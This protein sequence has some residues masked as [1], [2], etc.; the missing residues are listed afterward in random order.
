MT[1][2]GRPVTANQRSTART[3]AAVFGKLGL[4]A[5][6]GLPKSWTRPTP[7]MHR[8]KGL[9]ETALLC[10]LLRTA[11]F[12]HHDRWSRRHRRHGRALPELSAPEQSQRSEENTS[13]LQS[14]SN[15]L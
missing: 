4:A 14:H 8:T 13:E 1:Y 15:L 9:D 7:Y 6:A 5:G 3:S 12:T 11:P 2:P 10:R